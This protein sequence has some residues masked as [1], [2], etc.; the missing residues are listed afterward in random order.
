MF[1]RDSN[2][3][4]TPGAATGVSEK[5]CGAG[6]QEQSDGGWVLQRRPDCNNI[7]PDAEERKR[8]QILRKRIK[9]HR[10]REKEEKIRRGGQG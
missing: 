6:G 10:G 3:W 1:E 7:L 9:T 4:G 2:P 8:T 5:L